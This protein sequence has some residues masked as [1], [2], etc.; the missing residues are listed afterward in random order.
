[1]IL[2]LPKLEPWQQE[3]FDDMKDQFTSSKIFVVKSKRQVGKSIL[4]LA[5]LLYYS[6]AFYRR[7]SVVIEPTLNQSRRIFKQFVNLL[8]GTGAIA[9]ANES[10]L[11]IRLSN[12][13][14]ILF[15]SA[16][17]REAL[18][19]FTVK[20]L[21]VIDEA[22]YIMD[23]IFDLLFPTVDANK[24]PILMISTPLFV[25]GRFYEY[26]TMGLDSSQS[27]VKSYD[28]NLYDTSKFLSEENLEFYR[29][30][31]TPTKF[32]T[33]Y[34]GLFITEGSLVFGNINQCINIHQPLKPKY[35]GIDWATG[36]QN[37][38]TVITLM[39]ENGTVVDIFAFNNKDST[40]QVNLISDILLKNKVEV[41]Q[42]EL[43]SIGKVYYD[44]LKTKV[45]S[46]CKLVGFTTS[47]SSKREIVENLIK[48]FEN[49]YISVPNRSQLIQE[50]QHYE[51]Q[52]LKTGY[53]Y[54]G[55]LGFHDDYVM[56]LAFAYDLVIKKSDYIVYFLK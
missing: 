24:S 47:N 13:S 53:T 6:V 52:K 36:V 41:A 46:K 34:L 45:G 15:K 54:N 50:L 42:V 26:Y 32:Q 48:A 55:A 37:D 16:E 4:A 5:E 9:Q 11:T 18:R 21:L 43:N 49:Q 39:D 14:E 56:S 51:M 35:A 44:F 12:E 31:L 33:D 25:T 38:D 3:V 2:Q 40:E 8:N 10:L 28:W 29:K 7:T 22:A 1:M 23:D 27:K 30:S 19:G 17:Q 20:G